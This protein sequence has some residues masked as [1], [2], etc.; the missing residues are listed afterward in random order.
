M[1]HRLGVLSPSGAVTFGTVPRA[2]GLG[3]VI[4]VLLFLL[5]GGPPQP[6]STA[7]GAPERLR[8]MFAAASAS[9][10][11]TPTASTSPSMTA[12]ASASP[13]Q[14]PTP[15]ASESPTVTPSGTPSA[16]VSVT[17]ASTAS[18]APLRANLSRVDG[19]LG[20][21]V[22]PAWRPRRSSAVLPLSTH[23]RPGEG[24]ALLVDNFFHLYAGPVAPRWSAHALRNP[25]LGALNLTSPPRSPE[26]A[27]ADCAGARRAPPLPQCTPLE[28][29]ALRH[30][31]VHQVASFPSYMSGALIVDSGGD[32]FA[33]SLATPGASCQGPPGAP[34]PPPLPAADAL[35]DPNPGS[36][37]ALLWHRISSVD[38]QLHGRAFFADASRPT[39]ASAATARLTDVGRSRFCAKR[40]AYH[41]DLEP[42]PRC[43]GA[44]GESSVRWPYCNPPTTSI[45][46][47]SFDCAFIE[48][49]AAPEIAWNIM[50]LDAGGVVISHNY[51]RWAAPGI[52][53][54]EFDELACAG[55]AVYPTS[56]GHFFNEILPRL[57]ALDLLLPQHV[58]LLWPSGGMAERTLADFVAAGILSSE[59]RFPLLSAGGQQMTRARR[60]Y[61]FAAGGEV[62]MARFSPLILMISHRLM[63]ASIHEAVLA[64]D[65]AARSG[66]QAPPTLVHNGI[67]VLT[68]AAGRARSIAN[69]AALLDALRAAFP[70]RHIDA[71]EPV[72]P[73]L[74]VAQRVYGAELII[75]PH[76]AN[77]NNIFGARAGTALIEIGYAGGMEMPSDYFCLARNLGLEYW[78][79]PSENGEY[80]TPVTAY[81]DDVVGIARDALQRRAALAAAAGGGGGGGGGGGP[82]TPTGSL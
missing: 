67:V 29:G 2:F 14:T 11:L 70:T 71:F 61:S 80:G 49:F 5:V 57:V 19:I 24:A 31:L 38:R 42:E 62:E 26:D 50:S 3:A 76:G 21:P 7:L 15:T 27:A 16:T 54:E 68:R 46:V 13:S 18:P 32:A 55:T 41:F 20:G 47:V 52:A 6:G 60:L 82:G 75:G 17:S 64:R 4:G 72:I 73:F 35:G 59:R 37:R 34:P 53:V 28:N 48:S 69:E 8:A 44:A 36:V 63:A 39:G 66:G 23:D 33:A 77:L 51:G 56:P 40:E 9:P 81:I 74:D 45:A 65:A 22:H 25:L 1:N 58:P 78:L 12:S 30:P 79:S 10:S 43:D